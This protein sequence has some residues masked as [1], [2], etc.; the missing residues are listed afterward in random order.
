MGKK[1]DAG[2]PQEVKKSA[3]LVLREKVE[4]IIQ[5]I[6]QQYLGVQ[7]EQIDEILTLLSNRIRTI[8]TVLKDKLGITDPELSAIMADIEDLRMGLVKVEDTIKVGDVVRCGVAVKA[9]E[10]E[11]YP[12]KQNLKFVD[13]GGQGNQ[14]DVAIVNGMLGMGIA[15]EKEVDFEKDGKTFTAKISID[16]ISRRK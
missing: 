4:P 8:E 11:V 9:K 15:E 5:E 13:F 1:K 14:L 2:L 16:R 10:E 7:Q 6:V 3:E 12:N